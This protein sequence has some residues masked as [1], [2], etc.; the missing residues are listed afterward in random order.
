MI[1]HPI[2]NQ[3]QL[4]I[5][6][7]LKRSKE[8]DSMRCTQHSTVQHQVVQ[9]PSG[10]SPCPYSST[11]DHVQQRDRNIKKHYQHEARRPLALPLCH[12]YLFARRGQQ[13]MLPH[14]N[15]IKLVSFTI[16]NFP[17]EVFITCFLLPP[18]RIFKR[19]RD[20]DAQDDADMQ[21][22][23]RSRMIQRLVVSRRSTRGSKA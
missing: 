14:F 22:V 15:N 23:S 7:A 5:Q 1:S 2:T 17:S 16:Y 18:G 9:R 12:Q 6:F 19:C 4:R 13:R 11:K 8:H 3:Q 10:A 21:G 20:A